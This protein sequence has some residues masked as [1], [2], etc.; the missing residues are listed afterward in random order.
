MQEHY[1]DDGSWY[2]SSLG[3]FI[4]LL[5]DAGRDP[6]VCFRIVANSEPD[7]EGKFIRHIELFM[8]PDGY[9]QAGIKECVSVHKTLQMFLKAGVV[10]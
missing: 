10:K 6:A 5:V 1:Y 4:S 9:V 8:L 3:H 7:K 2:A